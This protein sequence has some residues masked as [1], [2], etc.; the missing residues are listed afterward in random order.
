LCCH[1]D[2]QN[3]WYF[4]DRKV[5]ELNAVGYLLSNGSVPVETCSDVWGLIYFKIHYLIFCKLCSV[6]GVK[7]VT[8]KGRMKRQ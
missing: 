6:A 4:Y 5:T 1:Y 2:W 7:S 8:A 3:A